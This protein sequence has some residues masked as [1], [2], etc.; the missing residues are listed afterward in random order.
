MIFFIQNDLMVWCTCTF[1]VILF[2]WLP[3]I[4]GNSCAC[5]VMAG[6][7]I[8]LTIL[9]LGRIRHGLSGLQ[10]LSV[11]LS[12]MQSLVPIPHVHVYKWVGKNDHTIIHDHSEIFHKRIMLDQMIVPVTS[13]TRPTLIRLRC[14]SYNVIFAKV[15]LLAFPK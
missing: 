4:P 12:V 7:P 1:S 9:F 14:F 6:W 3:H 8:N 15:V 11:Y 2:Y 13:C 10:A 5:M